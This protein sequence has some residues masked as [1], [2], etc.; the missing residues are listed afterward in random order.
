MEELHSLFNIEFSKILAIVVKYHLGG[1][2]SLLLSHWKQYS[3]LIIVN[4]WSADYSSCY[5]THANLTDALYKHKLAIESI[6]NVVTNKVQFAVDQQIDI[7]KS[8]DS[9]SSSFIS[10]SVEEHETNRYR[11]IKFIDFGNNSITKI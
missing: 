5:I 11:L 4:D 6:S 8:D 3:G 7:L 10:E 2:F 1:D 9:L